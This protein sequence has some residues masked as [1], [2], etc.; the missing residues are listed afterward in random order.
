MDMKK[1]QIL[2]SA[3]LLLAVACTNAPVKETAVSGSDSTSVD[4]TTVKSP[5]DSIM[6]GCYSWISNR[7]T[8][9]LQ[10]IVKGAN[11]SGPLTYRIYEKDRNDGTFTGEVADGVL[12]GWYLF[13]SEGVMSVRQAIWKI[14]PNGELWP[15]QGE[16]RQSNDS[17]YFRTNL[18]F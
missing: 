7:D 16:M 3:L 17:S 14:Q 12:T 9:T 11:I 15:A 10:L 13:R 6:T 4:S 8:A 2:G 1:L 5:A 18:F